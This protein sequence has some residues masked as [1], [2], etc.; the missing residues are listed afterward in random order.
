MNPFLTDAERRDCAME[1]MK[2]LLLRDGEISNE[3]FFMDYGSDVVCCAASSVFD[4]IRALHA[5]TGK[6]GSLEAE[7]ENMLDSAVS[8][9]VDA[10]MESIR[11]AQLQAHIEAEAEYLE[12]I[13]K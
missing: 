8:E 11:N 4:A 13:G 12:R 6:P 3:F 1:Q 10:Y 9:R 7:L 2:E 5:G